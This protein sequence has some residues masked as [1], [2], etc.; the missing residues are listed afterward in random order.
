[1][2]TV[3]VGMIGL[4]GVGTWGHLHGY[5][6]IPEQ[7]K[8]VAFCDTNPGVIN[9]PAR[10]HGAKTYSDYNQLIADPNFDIVDVAVPHFLHGRIALAAVKA[11][12]NVICEKPFTTTLP[13]ADA[14]IA[15]AKDRGVK[16]MVAEN[17]RFVRA[18]QV[19][20]EFI[21]KEAIGKICF[22][23][24]YLG[25]SEM[26]RL[27]DPDNW[28]GKKNTAGGGVMFDA[29][30]HSFYLLRWMVGEMNSVQAT[31]MTFLK[32]LYQDV[33][34]NAMGVIHFKNG[35]IA[36]FTLS[37]TTEAPWTERL[38]LFGTKGSIIVD[39]LSEHPVQVFS[40]KNRSEDMSDWW[41]HYGDV[42]WMEP[43]ISH[44]ALEWKPTSM[45][46]EVQH[47]VE[48]VLEDKQPFVTGEDGRRDVEISLK[49]YESAKIGKEVPV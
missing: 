9:E 40:T 25:G 27:S 41:S 44:S 45:R 24:T 29:G 34:D 30:V 36:N 46:R 14:I 5:E 18:Y 12:K 47:F 13:E 49:C 33:E 19:A 28:I 7:A 38:E 10:L 31:T 6:E 21:Q 20:Y 22:A 16:L 32:N 8:L 1:M 48:C 4:G 23:R 15:E 11:G 35:A 39:L 42:G 37:N 17:T 26:I 3:R 2:D 43:F